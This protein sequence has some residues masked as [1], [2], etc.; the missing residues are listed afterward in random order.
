M[1]NKI[2]LYSIA[3][4]LLSTIIMLIS[5]MINFDILIRYATNSVMIFTTLLCCTI[6]FDL[7]HDK[8]KND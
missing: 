5:M 2:M 6:V 8:I 7:V 3:M 4:I 1:I